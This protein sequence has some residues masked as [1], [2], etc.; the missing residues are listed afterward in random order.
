MKT[1]LDFVSLQVRDRTE[2][3]T[4]YRDR[5]GFTVTPEENPAATVFAD[6]GGAIFAVRDP[7]VPLPAD[8][9][10]GLGVSLWFTVAEK[11]EVLQQR[12][13]ETGVRILKPP[14]DTPFGRS[15]TVA[16]P[17]GYAITLHQSLTR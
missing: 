5:L 17:D 10:L 3:T 9:L 12:L 8:Q 14:F 4:F 13:G 15:L 6:A 2:S 1:I 11:V 16:D 7:F